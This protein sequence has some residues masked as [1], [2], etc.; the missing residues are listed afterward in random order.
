MAADEPINVAVS[1][2]AGRMGATVCEAVEGADDMA[3]VGRADPKLG[4]AVQD[5][6]GDADVVVDFSQPGTAI[7]NARECLEAGVHVVMGTTGA[8]FS[9]LEGV[10]DAK[11]FV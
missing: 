5:V 6:I 7:E 2:A 8:D 4:V 11:L 1:G 3:L 10:G 9:V